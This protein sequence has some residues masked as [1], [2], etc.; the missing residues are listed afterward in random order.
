LRTSARHRKQTR[1]TS[2]RSVSLAV[3]PE[4]FR[5]YVAKGEWKLSLR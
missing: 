5:S 1:R 2:Q 4:P 3:A